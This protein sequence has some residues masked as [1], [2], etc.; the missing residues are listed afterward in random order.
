MSSHEGLGNFVISEDEI[1]SSAF[2][3]FEL[4]RKNNDIVSGREV[5]IRLF[6][7]LDRYVHEDIDEI[8]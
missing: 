4:P 5:E 8:I 1:E 3:L 7:V 2:E 6:T